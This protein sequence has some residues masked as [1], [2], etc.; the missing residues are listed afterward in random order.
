MKILITGATGFVGSRFVARWQGE[1][2]LLTPSH[3]E[4]PI[5]NAEA[6]LLYVGTAKPDVV[7]HL[8]AISNTWHCEQHPDESRAINVLGAV[9]MAQAA[10]AVGAKFI[11]FSSDQIYNGN[12][13]LGGLPETI[14]VRPENVYGRD[15]LEAERLIAE[16]DE[17]AVLLRATWMYDAELE[18]MRTHPNFVVNIANALRTQTPLSF[19]TRE[20]RGITNI[21]EVVEILPHCF[22]IPG[23]VYNFGAENPLNTYDTALAYA[24]LLQEQ[25]PEAFIKVMPEELILPDTK[26]FPTHIRNISIDMHKLHA[27]LPHDVHFSTTM[28]G[29]EKFLERDTLI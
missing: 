27:V 3:A 8:A 13:E 28:E 22:N 7:L 5:D 23:G 4:L 12:E 14:A 9:N 29:L 21:R 18:G 2:T 10:K 26:R 19:A 20:Y 15:K 24:R 6:A 16:V 1:Y 17:A 25:T 11:F